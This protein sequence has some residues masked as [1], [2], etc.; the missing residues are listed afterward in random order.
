VE[1]IASAAKGFVDVTRFGDGRRSGD[2]QPS[3]GESD[4]LEIL[5]EV[6]P[7][8]PELVWTFLYLEAYG[9]MPQAESERIGRKST[10]RPTG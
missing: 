4:F 3:H 7:R 8:T 6:G 1:T 10:I 2:P 9:E 5:K